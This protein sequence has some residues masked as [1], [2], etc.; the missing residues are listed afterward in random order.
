MPRAILDPNVPV[1]AFIAPAGASARLLLEL[2]AGA[3]EL[4]TSHLLL[5]ELATV[6]ARDKFRRYSTD[7]EADA[8][9]RLVRAESLVLDDPPGMPEPLSA[10]PDDDYLI[11][12]AR[13]ARADALVSGDPHLLRLRG[14]VP[15][16]P[17]RE[18]LDLLEELERR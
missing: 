9:V 6:L 13:S 10:D 8:Y 16:L 12:L 5:A 7:D 1:S 3:F 18:F 11:V 2:R 14:R 17:P 4:V 15:V